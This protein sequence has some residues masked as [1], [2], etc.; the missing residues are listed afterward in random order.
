MVTF[1]YIYLTI[2]IFVPQQVNGGSC[3]DILNSN[4]VPQHLLFLNALVCY[5]VQIGNESHEPEHVDGGNS[6]DTLNWS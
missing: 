3:C 2:F 5:L 1:F 4:R 6:S